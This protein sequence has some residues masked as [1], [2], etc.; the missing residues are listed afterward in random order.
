MGRFGDYVLVQWLK[1]K[2]YLGEVMEKFGDWLTLATRSV[3]AL[4]W[5]LGGIVLV[6]TGY[7][8]GPAEL[9]VAGAILIFAYVY[10]RS[11]R[12]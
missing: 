11:H 3:G 1:I 10:H 9:A 12:P 7:N 5:V 6:L 4:V 2:E 8:E